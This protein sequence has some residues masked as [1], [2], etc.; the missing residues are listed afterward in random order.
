MPL[1][2]EGLHS[3]TVAE[4]ISSLI[5]LI[6][7]CCRE[8]SVKLRKRVCDS[9]LLKSREHHFGVR[10]ASKPMSILFQFL[11][12]SEEIV[13]FSVESDNV[14]AARGPHRLVPSRAEINNGK[15]SMREARVPFRR[16]PNVMCVRSPVAL[17]IV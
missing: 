11:A 12:K 14:S 9:P 13:D 15:P 2:I 8:H 1:V 5:G 7:N 6:P 4:E 17:S 10:C 16:N 3:Q